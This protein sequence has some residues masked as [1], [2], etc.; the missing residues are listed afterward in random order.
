[1]VSTIA[2]WWFCLAMVQLSRHYSNG[3]RIV[4]VQCWTRRVDG[5]NEVNS[6]VCWID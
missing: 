1:M 5:G 3:E 4:G 6:A 2:G